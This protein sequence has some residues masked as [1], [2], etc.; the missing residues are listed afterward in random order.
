[1]PLESPNLDDRTWRELVGGATARIQQEA[2][3]WSDLSPGDPG[4][5]LLEVFA[6]LTE[7]LLY[8]L[9]RVPDKLFIEFLRL[10]GVR[11]QPPAAAGVDLVFTR[12]RGTTARDRH[13]ARDARHDRPARAAASRRSSRRPNPAIDRR[14]RGERHRL[15]AVHAERIEAESLG[16]GRRGEPGLVVTVARPPI[17]APTED[18]LDLDRRGRGRS[19][20]PRGRRPGHRARRARPIAIWREVDNF[21]YLGADRFVY[22]AD[23]MAGSI[24]FAPAARSNDDDAVLADERDVVLADD[25]RGARGHAAARAR[26]PRLVPARRRRRGQRRRGHADDDQG[27][28]S[29]R[30]SRTRSRRPAA[31]RPRR[32]TTPASAAR[33]SCT[34]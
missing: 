13:P 33:R 32:S 1:M 22:L 23:R 25:A 4:I 9:N 16:A 18:G 15:R 19:S 28:R 31:A 30:P 26:H 17:I 8:R 34:R 2:P 6:Y 24:M 12:E 20:R 10:I 21:T 29:G 7:S 27:R 5:V 14:R 11:L 3:E